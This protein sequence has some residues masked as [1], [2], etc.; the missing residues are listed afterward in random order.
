MTVGGPMRV[1]GAHIPPLGSPASVP[2]LPPLPYSPRWL[3]RAAPVG[4]SPPPPKVKPV[5]SLVGQAT[6]S[7]TSPRACAQKVAFIRRA[8]DAAFDEP[9]G[10]K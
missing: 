2:P 8:A 9:P 3:V 4:V 5:R 1:W 7:S 6:N 10:I